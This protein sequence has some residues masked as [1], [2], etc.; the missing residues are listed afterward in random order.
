MGIFVKCPECGK[1]F[2]ELIY[3]Q[4]PECGSIKYKDVKEMVKC[5]NKQCGAMINKLF[6]RCPICGHEITDNTLYYEYEKVYSQN[7]TKDEPSK[8]ETENESTEETTIPHISPNSPFEYPFTYLVLRDA[9]FKGKELSIGRLMVSCLVE[10]IAGGL[11]VAV[12]FIL[13][14][15]E[16]HMARGMA[17]MAL[18][19]IIIILHGFYTLIRYTIL[20]LLEKNNIHKSE[21][22]TRLLLFLCEIVIGGIFIIIILLSEANNG[23]DDLGA[24]LAILGFGMIVASIISIGK[25]IWT[26]IKKR[27]KGETNV[28]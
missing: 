18:G 2:N 14:P 21:L 12:S 7:N 13:N 16:S 24:Y 1:E 3:S 20:L 27:K 10:M 25:Y 5:S 9:V 23:N 4:C 22:V 26:Q 8:K 28:L 15:F 19:G 11:I 17:L 6:T